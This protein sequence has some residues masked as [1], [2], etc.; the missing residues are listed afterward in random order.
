M[1]V[2]HIIKN[3]HDIVILYR[4]V[5]FQVDQRAIIMDKIIEIILSYEPERTRRSADKVSSRN[6]L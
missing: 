2:I 4:V 6:I 1:Y 5:Y 3:G